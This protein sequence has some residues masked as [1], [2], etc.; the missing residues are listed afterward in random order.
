MAVQNPIRIERMFPK[1]KSLGS[2]A[3]AKTMLFPGGR[4]APG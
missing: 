4:I 1:D 2:R 3:L